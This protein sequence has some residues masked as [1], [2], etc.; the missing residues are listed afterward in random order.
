VVI[1]D[2]ELSLDEFLDGERIEPLFQQFGLD[3]TPRAVWTEA[4]L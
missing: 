1:T 4:D 2:W 3:L